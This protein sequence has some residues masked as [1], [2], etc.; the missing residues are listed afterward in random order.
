MDFTK[1][2]EILNNRGNQNEDSTFESCPCA[3]DPNRPKVDFCSVCNTDQLKQSKVVDLSKNSLVEL[4]GMIFEIQ[5]KRIKV[6]ESPD[7]FVIDN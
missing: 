6:L 1:C 5:H 7:P 4:I 2:M 3:S